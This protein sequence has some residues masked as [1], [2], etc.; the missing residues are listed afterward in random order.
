MK[1][2]PRGIPNIENTDFDIEK[3]RGRTFLKGDFPPT[4]PPVVHFYGGAI[5]HPLKR[6]ETSPLAY[7]LESPLSYPPFE[8]G[9]ASIVQFDVGTP[10]SPF[11][12]CKY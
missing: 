2:K 11:F 1:N 12:F 3:T 7:S 8:F 4:P 5:P 9:K 10:C 6:V